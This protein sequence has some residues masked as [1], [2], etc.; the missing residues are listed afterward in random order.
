M[1]RLIT[2]ERDEAFV[3]QNT[4]AVNTDLVSQSNYD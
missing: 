3:K 1:Q 4:G 2:Q